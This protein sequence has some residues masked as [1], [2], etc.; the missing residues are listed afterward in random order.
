ML[1]VLPDKKQTLSKDFVER[2]F[3]IFGPSE[4]L[5]SDQGPEFENKVA[6]QLK[7]VFGYKRTE[8]TPY[9]PQGNSVSERMHSALHAML[10]CAEI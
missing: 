2:V 3:G 10:R 1:V 8:M 5:G 7:D 6:K 9:R 4:T